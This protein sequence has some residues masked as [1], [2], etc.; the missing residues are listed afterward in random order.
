MGTAFFFAINER[1]GSLG[2][3]GAVDGIA[4]AS[5]LGARSRDGLE[6]DELEE[7]FDESTPSQ[8]CRR[9][10]RRQQVDVLERVRR[11]DPTGPHEGAASRVSNSSKASEWETTDR[12]D[13]MAMVVLTT[14]VT[15]QSSHSACNARHF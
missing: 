8:G 6:E 4:V 14:A 15:R 12:V 11:A 3:A 13:V 10:P 1:R 2:D 9:Q 5:A 7:L